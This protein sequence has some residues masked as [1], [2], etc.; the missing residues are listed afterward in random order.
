MTRTYPSAL[1]SD[2]DKAFAG[3]VDDVRLFDAALSAAE[4]LRL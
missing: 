4:E 3:A 2:G 1:I